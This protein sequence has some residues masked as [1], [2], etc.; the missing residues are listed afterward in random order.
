MAPVEKRKHKEMNDGVF[1]EKRKVQ[2]AQI[3][4]GRAALSPDGFYSNLNQIMA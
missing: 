4:P 2:S 1:E 3:L